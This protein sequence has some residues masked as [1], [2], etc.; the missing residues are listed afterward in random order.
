MSPALNRSSV[1]R[2]FEGSYAVEIRDGVSTQDCHN[3]GVGRLASNYLSKVLTQISIIIVWLIHMWQSLIN[4]ECYSV[5]CFECI[6]KFD[7]LEC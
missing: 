2:C 1:I 3:Y 5:T 7:A 4:I 6:T